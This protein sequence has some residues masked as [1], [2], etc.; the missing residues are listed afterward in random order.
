MGRHEIGED[1]ISYSV[2]R[3]LEKE[4]TRMRARLC[5][6]RHKCFRFVM[7][8]GTHFTVAVFV[9]VVAAGVYYQL[10]MLSH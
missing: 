9:H 10:P 8:G 3:M 2:E 1:G 6:I 7:H 5:V 4:D